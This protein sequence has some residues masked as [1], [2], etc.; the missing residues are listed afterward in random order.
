MSKIASRYLEVDPWRIVEKG[1]HRDRDKVSESIFSVGNEFM[2]V[3]GYFEEGYGGPSTL[4]SYFNGI[5]EYAPNPKKE[6]F[7]G[8]PDRYHFLVNTVDWLHTRISAEGEK[9]DLAT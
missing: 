4:G 5:F 9:L 8:T 2:G 1:F 6:W 3:R 7:N